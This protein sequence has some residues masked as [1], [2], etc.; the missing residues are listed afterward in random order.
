KLLKEQ[1]DKIDAGE[2]EQVEN[3]LN[4]VKTALAGSDVEA[5]KDATEAL[6]TASQGFAQKLYEASA[7]EAQQAGGGP[8]SAPNDD[9]VVD[10]EIVD[11]QGA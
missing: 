8:S 7:Q 5:I 2:R 6:M 4:G 9:D 11:E 1:G 10:A 3:A